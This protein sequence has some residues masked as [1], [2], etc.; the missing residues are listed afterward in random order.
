MPALGLTSVDNIWSRSGRYVMVCNISCKYH[1]T[2][3]RSLTRR[4]GLFWTQKPVSRWCQPTLTWGFKDIRNDCAVFAVGH[5]QCKNIFCF[6]MHRHRGIASVDHLYWNPY[7]TGFW[8]FALD[9]WR[10]FG[11]VRPQ[12]RSHA[13]SMAT[14]INF[15]DINIKYKL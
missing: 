5:F 6:K 12:R 1:Y 3:P 4:W 2:T 7:Y 10:F 14:V 11:S 15:G 13:L 8:E 9:F